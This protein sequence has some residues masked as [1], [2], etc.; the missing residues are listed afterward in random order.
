MLRNRT[1]ILN[2]ERMNL[3][4]STSP[5]CRCKA[6]SQRSGEQCRKAAMRGKTVCRSH[7]GASTGPRTAVGRLWCVDMKTVHD[8]ECRQTREVRAE[9]L[10]E[11][12]AQMI[13]LGMI[14]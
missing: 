14:G 13:K 12:K 8:R 1:V 3:F 6:R 10:R 7:G 4:G 2:A 9:K 5:A 11:L